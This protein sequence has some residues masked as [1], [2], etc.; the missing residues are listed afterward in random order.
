ME[1]FCNKPPKGTSKEALKAL[2]KAKMMGKHFR[3]MDPNYRK[4]GWVRPQNHKGVM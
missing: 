1:Q 3:R 2:H 4:T